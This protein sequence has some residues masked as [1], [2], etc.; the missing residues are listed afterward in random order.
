MAED[1]F[2]DEEAALRLDDRLGRRLEQDDVVGAFA[3]PPEV[4]I[5]RVVRSMTAW[6]LSS[7]TSGRRT[8]MSSYRRMRQD[9]PSNGIC[10]ADGDRRRG[11]ERK[12]GAV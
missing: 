11:A 8:S 7:A 5:W 1:F 6:A 3:I 9:T 10:P 12:R 4:L 2:G